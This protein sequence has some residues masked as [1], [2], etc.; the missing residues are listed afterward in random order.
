VLI[1]Q[2]EWDANYENLKLGGEPPAEIQWLR[3]HVPPGKGRRYL[4][5]GCFPGRF[6]P[7]FG[8]LGYE[9]NGVDLTP[10]TTTDLPAWLHSEGFSLG[11]FHQEDIRTFSRPEAYDVVASFGLIEHFRDWHDVVHR[12]VQCLKTG[13]LLI[14]TVPNF[15]NGLQRFLHSTL[16]RPNYLGHNREPMNPDN[17]G[18]VLRDAGCRVCALEFF[19]S[20]ALWL[21]PRPSQG[22]WRYVNPLARRTRFFWKFIPNCGRLTCPGLGVVAGKERSVVP[23]A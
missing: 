12:H 1:P 22:I 20:F 8:S 5:L 16:D 15:A 18:D 21:G 17:L 9:L 13:G 10:R 14:L 6:M 23:L 19:G 11:Q 2:R 7:L 4:E 3:P